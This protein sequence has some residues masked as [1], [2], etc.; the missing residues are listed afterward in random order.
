MA[1]LDKLTSKTKELTDSA[2]LSLKLAEEKRKLPELYERLGQFV[3]TRYQMG[4][5]TDEAYAQIINTI[6]SVK[7]SIRAIGDEIEEKRT[8]VERKCVCPMCGAMNTNT[9]VCVICGSE[10]PA[11]A[12]DACD[13]GCECGDACCDEEKTDK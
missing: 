6:L 2:K 1:F 12:D 7:E 4:E 11:P 3:F 5:A 10:I 8:Y 9:D 13:C